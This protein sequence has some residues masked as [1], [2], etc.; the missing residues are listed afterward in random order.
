MVV[1]DGNYDRKK[2]ACGHA[3]IEYVNR[4]RGLSKE[5]VDAAIMPLLRPSSASPTPAT[6]RQRPHDRDRRRHPDEEDDEDGKGGKGGG[7][8]AAGNPIVM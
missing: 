2:T 7:L 1:Q 4:Y 3:D 8:G 6:A 5:Q